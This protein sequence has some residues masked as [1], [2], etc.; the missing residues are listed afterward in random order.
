MCVPPSLDKQCS[1]ARERR[2]F[3]REQPPEFTSPAWLSSRW[4][5]TRIVP[6]IPRATRDGRPGPETAMRAI[7][8]LA[9][10]SS[11]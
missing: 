9:T 11:R 10:I 3:P 8:K 7:G 6:C 1:A 4:G 5:M 2:L